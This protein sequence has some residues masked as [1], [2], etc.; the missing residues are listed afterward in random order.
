MTPVQHAH[1]LS[2]DAA[3]TTPLLHKQ[4]RGTA[5]G[6][7]SDEL[8]WRAHTGEYSPGQKSLTVKQQSNILCPGMLCV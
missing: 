5:H 3:D 4:L 2:I 7:R 1:V 8:T 6:I